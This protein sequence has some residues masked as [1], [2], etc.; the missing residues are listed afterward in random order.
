MYQQH[1]HKILRKIWAGVNWKPTHKKSHFRAFLFSFPPSIFYWKIPGDPFNLCKLANRHK[2]IWKHFP[3]IDA[4][5]MCK[6]FESINKISNWHKLYHVKFKG[7]PFGER[8]VQCNFFSGCLFVDWHEEKKAQKKN[9]MV[10]IYFPLPNRINDNN[11]NGALSWNGLFHYGG[12]K[13]NLTERWMVW[14][15]EKMFLCS[16]KNNVN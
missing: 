16:F 6:A 8:G 9:R 3:I 14:K 2:I 15:V 11:V 13:I 10:F 7:I 12:L 5:G 1:Q 4:A